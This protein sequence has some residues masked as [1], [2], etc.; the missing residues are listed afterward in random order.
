MDNIYIKVIVSCWYL[1]DTLMKILIFHKYTCNTLQK[2]QYL[3]NILIII[4]KSF[5]I[6][7]QFNSFKHTYLILIFFLMHLFLYD[8]NDNIFITKKFIINSLKFIF[9]INAV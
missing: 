6:H 1:S 8:I 4:F 7:T 5:K 3:F 9:Y 2:F